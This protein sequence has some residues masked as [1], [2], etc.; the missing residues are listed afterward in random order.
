MLAQGKGAYP[1]ERRYQSEGV[2]R[3]IRYMQIRANLFFR[4]FEVALFSR[5]QMKSLGA[6]IRQR[7]SD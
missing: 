5:K 1:G 2:I 7:I 6:E 3:R 4:L